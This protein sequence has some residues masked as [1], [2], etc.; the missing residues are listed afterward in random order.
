MSFLDALQHT[1]K[2]E[3]GYA[4][5]PADR[6]GETFRGISRL[7]WPAWPGWELIDRAK[8]RGAVSARLINA[9]FAGDLDME[10]LVADF[11]QRHFWRPF[12]SLRAPGRI[13]AKLFDTAVNVGVGGAVKM[14]QRV[15]NQSGPVAPLVV[16]GVIGPKTRAGFTLSVGGAGDEDSFLQ[17]FCREQE[18]HYR[19]IVGRNPG[20]SK[21]LKGWLRRAEWVPA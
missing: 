15:V 10:R 8:I 5:D 18:A 14:L 17:A 21:F 1:L 12:E 11:Y 20:Q 7:N 3:G 2:F 13:P 4:N 19:R 9:A 6:G 16:D